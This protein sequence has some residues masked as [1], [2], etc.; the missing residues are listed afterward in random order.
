NTA[1]SENNFA[2]AEA[3]A[4]IFFLIVAA[5]SLLQVYYTRKREVDL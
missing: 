2:L 4:L 3:K 1:Y 5:I